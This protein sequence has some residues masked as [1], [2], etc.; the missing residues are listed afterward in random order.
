MD[1]KDSLDFWVD[2]IDDISD[3]IDRTYHRE[4]KHHIDGLLGAVRRQ[5]SPVYHNIRNNVQQ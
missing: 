3:H 5:L 4:L 2:C 1:I